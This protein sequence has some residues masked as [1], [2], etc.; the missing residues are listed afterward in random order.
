MMYSKHLWRF[1]LKNKKS[2]YNK[3][4]IHKNNDKNDTKLFYGILFA[5]VL[6]VLLAKFINGKFAL[7]FIITLGVA[8]SSS[9]LM[10]KYQHSGD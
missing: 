10:K 3:K 7:R 2:K 4:N 8:Y 5:L 6:V 1:N 9:R